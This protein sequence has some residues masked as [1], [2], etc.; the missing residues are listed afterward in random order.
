MIGGWCR[1][2]A[3]GTRPTTLVSVSARVEIHFHLLPAV[4][5]GPVTLDEAVDLARL[6]VADGTGRVVATPHVRDVVVAEIPE[7]VLE[8]RAALQRAAV[9]LAVDAGAELAADDVAWATGPDLEIMAQGPPGRRWIL[10]EA[11]LE[12]VDAG[13]HEAAQELRDR[14]FAVVVGHPERSPDF[15]RAGGEAI[16]VELER[17]AVLQV[18]AS[19][20]VGAHGETARREGLALIRAGVVGAV[21]SDAHRARR[22]PRLGVAVERLVTDGIARATAE[23]L[24]STGPAGLVAAGLAPIAPAALRT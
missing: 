7:R 21:A 6:A 2:L 3:R 5:D 11:P 13:Y 8:L 16:R 15:L 20:L 24:V 23:A 9:P 19:S 1:D 10:L 18:N 4:D 22:P 17:G 12:P 14:G